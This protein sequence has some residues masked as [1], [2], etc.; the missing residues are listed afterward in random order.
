MVR[1]EA[2][3]R[4]T[5]V[6]ERNTLHRLEERAVTPLNRP[7]EKRHRERERERERQAISRFCKY[8][9]RRVERTESGIQQ[10][11]DLRR[12]LAE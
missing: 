4:T 5:A 8:R 11:H 3:Q 6:Q 9:Q 1:R 10:V 7:E 2:W 12:D